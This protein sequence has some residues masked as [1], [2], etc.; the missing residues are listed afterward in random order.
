MDVELRPKA[1]REGYADPVERS[2]ALL[3]AT[4]GWMAQAFKTPS[5]GAT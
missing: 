2:R 3:A 1:L 5:C 4:W